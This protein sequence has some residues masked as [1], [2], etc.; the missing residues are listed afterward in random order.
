MKGRQAGRCEGVLQGMAS[1]RLLHPLE[2]GAAQ[3]YRPTPFQTS[4]LGRAHLKLHLV[5]G[6]QLLPHLA[7]PLDHTLVVQLR[8]GGCKGRG[9]SKGGF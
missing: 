6:A 5:V 3:L 7:Q 1:C 8:V 9:V 4:T 2:Q